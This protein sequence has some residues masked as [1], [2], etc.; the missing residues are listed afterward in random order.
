MVERY[1]HMNTAALR[2]V[3]NNGSNA[4]VGSIAITDSAA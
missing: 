3:V 1:T 2:D 4:V